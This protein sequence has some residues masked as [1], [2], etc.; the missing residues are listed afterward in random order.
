MNKITSKEIA[1][2]LLTIEAVELRPDQPFTWSSGI[3]SPIYCDNR[4]IIG[5]PAVRKQIVEVFCQYLSS[6]LSDIDVIAGTSTAGIPHAAF[7]SQKLDL[8]MSY[9]RGSKKSHGKQNQIE[10]A[11][12]ARKR[13]V[14]IEDLISTGGSSLEVVDALQAAGA[15][16]VEVVA[17]FTYGMD[18][19]RKAFNAQQ[20]PL[21]TLCDLDTLLEVAEEAQ[22]ITLEQKQ[23][24]EQF[25]DLY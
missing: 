4:K 10:G 15:E 13:V 16:V 22:S 14:V 6:E 19:A 2:H 17:I 7:I 9:V 8:P 24:I 23:L 3:K 1:Q 11:Q 12:V 5:Q 25:R 18:R 21:H 20:V